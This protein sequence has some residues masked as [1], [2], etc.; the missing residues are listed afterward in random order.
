MIGCFAGIS[1]VVDDK[2]LLS[3]FSFFLAV[4][5]LVFLKGTNFGTKTKLVLIYGHLTFLFFPFVLFTTNLGC[6]I[7]CAPCQNNLISLTLLALPT[8]LV[9][10]TLV[11]ALAIP[12]YYIFSN[13]TREIKTRWMTKI[14]KFYANKLNFPVPKIYALDKAIPAAFSFRNFKSAIFFTVGLLDILNKKELEAVLLHEIAHIARK[15]SLLKLS[16]SILRFFSPLSVFVKFYHDSSE[17]ERYAD[18]FTIKEQK[19]NFHLDSAKQKMDNFYLNDR[20][21]RR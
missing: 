20:C 18:N 11:G 7:S 12:S 16:F 5:M 6:G 21:V 1:L 13:K 8:T 4:V 9:A 2:V 17:E 3:V 14:V 19:T 10:S 15:S